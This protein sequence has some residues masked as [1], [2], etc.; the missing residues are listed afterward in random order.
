VRDRLEILQPPDDLHALIDDGTI[1]LGAVKALVAAARRPGRDPPWPPRLHRAPRDFAAG[2]RV[3]ARPDVDRRDRR[4]DRRRL[5]PVR[6]RAAPS[7]RG[8]PRGQPRL[9]AQLL[10]ADRAGDKDL[11]AP[12]KLNPAGRTAR[13]PACPSAARTSS[14]PRR[15]APPTASPGGHAALIV[16]QDVADQLAADGIKAQLKHERARARSEREARTSAAEAAGQ[17]PAVAAAAGPGAEE[18]AKERR[19]LERQAELARCCSRLDSPASA[20]GWHGS[21]GPRFME[22]PARRNCVW[23]TDFS[24][25]ETLGA[26]VWQPGG[27]VD[28]VAKLALACPVSA[29]KTWR[30]AVG[31]LEHARDRAAELLGRPLVEDLTDPDTGE[32]TPIIVVSD[33]GACYRAAGFARHIAARP[34]RARPHTPHGAGDQRRRRALASVAQ[35]RAPVSARDRR[36]AR[37]PSTWTAISTAKTPADRTRRSTPSCRSTATCA[38]RRS[39]A[40]GC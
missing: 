2:R 39:P 37:W 9:P 1:P 35:I 6:R 20:A 27:V 29:T 18:Q 22:P 31:V 10:H 34:A 26:G 23:Q 28:Y 16:G 17:D 19:R 40:T 8:R 7:A 15:S 14:A 38:R 5:H 21:G 11:A 24:E 25:H 32:I 4:P 3:A 33:N 36:R 12:G 30:D 13:R